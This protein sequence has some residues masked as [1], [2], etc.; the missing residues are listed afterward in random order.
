VSATSKISVADMSTRDA[1]SRIFSGVEAVRTANVAFELDAYGLM[2][3]TGVVLH[4]DPTYLEHARVAIKRR[5]AG[6]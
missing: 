5:L 1:C 4:E 3:N 2:G 6:T